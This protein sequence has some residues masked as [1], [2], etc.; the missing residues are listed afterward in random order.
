MG[1]LSNCPKKERDTES[2]HK[3][4]KER[5]IEQSRSYLKEGANIWGHQEKHQSKI[6]D[7]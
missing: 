7:I 3:N 5:L 6:I 2:K 4:S 1:S